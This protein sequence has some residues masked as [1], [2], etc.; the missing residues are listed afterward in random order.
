MLRMLL[1][2]QPPACLSGEA[3]A[4]PGLAGAA[5]RPLTPAAVSLGLALGCRW[6]TPTAHVIGSSGLSVHLVPPLSILLSLPL[7]AHFL[8]TPLRALLLQEVLWPPSR[9]PRPTRCTLVGLVCSYSSS[10]LPGVSFLWL[11]SPATA[12]LVALNNRNKFSP[13]SEARSRRSRC[14]R[15]VLLPEDQGRGFPRL[16]QLPVLASNPGVPGLMATSRPS[17]PPLYLCPSGLCLLPLVRTSRW[18]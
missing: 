2:F 18:L 12:D 11:L 16:S 15:A 9:S 6:P 17:L 13:H 4:H 5:A 8:S 1:S 3:W 7:P 10:P 14:R